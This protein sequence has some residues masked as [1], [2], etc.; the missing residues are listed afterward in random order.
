MSRLSIQVLTDAE[1][2]TIVNAA[3]QVLE[4]TGVIVNCEEA[5][6]L[7]K[8]QAAILKATSLKSRPVW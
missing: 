6:D 3:L 5:L 1:K 8:M 2:E 4:R 7:L